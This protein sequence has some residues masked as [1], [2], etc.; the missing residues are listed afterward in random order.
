MLAQALTHIEDIEDSFW[1]P[2]DLIDNIR[3]EL[4]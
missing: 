4:A 2:K 1:K 3:K